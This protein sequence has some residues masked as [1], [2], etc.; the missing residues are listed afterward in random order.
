M[1]KLSERQELELIQMVV[2]NRYE[3][4]GDEWYK[5]IS[6]EIDNKLNPKSKEVEKWWRKKKK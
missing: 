3:Y 4:T 6:K 5:K 2:D 1:N